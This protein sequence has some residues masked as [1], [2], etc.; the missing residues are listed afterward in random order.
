MPFYEFRCSKCEATKEQYFEFTEKHTVS[1]ENDA[2]V[3]V[4][5]IF[6]TPAILRGTGWGGQ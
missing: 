4:K 5:V 3:M 1:C 2:T 6:P